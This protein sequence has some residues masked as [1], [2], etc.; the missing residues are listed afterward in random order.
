MEWTTLENKNWFIIQSLDIVSTVLVIA[1]RTLLICFRHVRLLKNLRN[2]RSIITKLGSIE[3]IIIYVS[4]RMLSGTETISFSRRTNLP[5]IC[6]LVRVCRPVIG[7]LLWYTPTASKGR[8]ALG[9][10]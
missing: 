4:L 1:I 9:L 3:C 7:S 5:L 8:T 6:C 10:V 2:G